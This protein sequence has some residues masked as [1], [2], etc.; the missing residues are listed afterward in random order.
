MRPEYIVCESCSNDT[1][2]R[3]PTN[4]GGGGGSG[5]GGGDNSDNIDDDNDA[6]STPRA[7]FANCIQSHDRPSC[8]AI[9]L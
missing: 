3:R 9:L 8:S 4:D 5:G 1:F 2:T 6:K 7:L